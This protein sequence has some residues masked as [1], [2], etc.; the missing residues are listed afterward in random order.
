MNIHQNL[1]HFGYQDFL[2]V[3]APQES[4]VL[5]VIR[6]LKLQDESQGPLSQGHKGEPLWKR[7]F[8]TGL[9]AIAA[10]NG[11]DEEEE[12]TQY[13]LHRGGDAHGDPI[14]H[15]CA[16]TT[17]ATPDPYFTGWDDIRV[18]AVLGRPDLSLVEHRDETPGDGKLAR[19]LSKRIP[20]QDI[21]FV[22]RSGPLA[23]LQQHDFQVWRD[24]AQTRR[25]FCYEAVDVDQ[26]HSLWD[27]S[28]EGQ[29]SKHEPGAI[30]V[31]VTDPA[32]TLNASKLDQIL[33]TKGVSADQLFGQGGRTNPVLFSRGSW[34]GELF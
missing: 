9:Q 18:S 26:S 1:S 6:H 30:Y 15:K 34:G 8:G 3:E 5:G 12:D 28:I 4:V 11:F 21:L 10:L 7:L 33:A 19:E 29:R 24:G 16:S 20:G 31:G 22:R 25:V 32:N 23:P 13:R 17:G 2:L 14:T 27:C